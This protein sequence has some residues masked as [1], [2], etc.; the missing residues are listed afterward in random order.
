MKDISISDYIKGLNHNV[1]TGLKKLKV[2][3]LEEESTGKYIAFVDDGDDSYD[4]EISINKDELINY[5]K[6]D[7]GKPDPCK[8]IAA[9]A[10][11][12]L[13]PAKTTILLP[14]KLKKKQTEV[15]Q[16]LEEIDVPALKNWVTELLL[17]NEDIQLSFRVHFLKK[18][19]YTSEELIK[20][21]KQAVKSIAG[22]KKK[23][24]Q[25]QLIKII[26]LWENIHTPVLEYCF[27]TIDQPATF[28]LI[29]TMVSQALFYQGELNINTNR[30]EKYI[31]SLLHSVSETI[32]PLK[33]E[34]S[35]DKLVD[36]LFNR[37]AIDNYSYNKHYLNA[38]LVLFELSGTH[39]IQLLLDKFSKLLNFH[40]H[41]KSRPGWYFEVSKA[42]YTLTLKYN[43][44]KT[45][46][47][48]FITQYAY[49]EYNI[50][51]INQLIQI[52]Q[53]ARAKN[54]C[55]ECINRNYRN[56]Y[57]VPY[58]Q[59]LQKILR[60][61]DDPTGVLEISNILLPITFNFEDYLTILGSIEDEKEKKEFRNKYFNKA[62]RVYGS[63]N[64]INFCFQ[65]LNHEQ[66]FKQMISLVSQFA[67]YPTILNYF[68]Q[69]FDADSEKLLLAI[70]DRGERHI[71]HFYSFTTDKSDEPV[72][73]LVDKVTERYDKKNVFLA[74][75]KYGRQNL[76]YKNAFVERFEQAYK[77]K[78]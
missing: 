14:K 70:L 15:S 34:E 26:T 53:L 44:F 32:H 65:I 11:R 31:D 73:Q 10:S 20:S 71:E 74:M 3:E 41:E 28:E 9:V 48:L 7:C 18:D 8:H 19:I 35:W 75:T 38:V 52:N 64:E 6:C 21:Y 17:K 77:E 40:Y 43:C 5:T 33:D 30:F 57:N 50:D 61:Q 66:N 12:I 23:I 78:M 51:L 25:S 13:S 16:L 63:Q 55:E 60:E 37:I 58:L 4:V 27:Q 62:K 24:D 42:F 45:Y 29:H 69:M 36:T 47:L 68:D 46:H 54:L 49:N 39:H 1:L 2:R 56:E 72:N 59:L 22:N 67:S 76:Y